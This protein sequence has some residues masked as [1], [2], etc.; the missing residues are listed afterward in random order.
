MGSLGAGACGFVVPDLAGT[1]TGGTLYN[2]QLIAA[3]ERAGVRC[4]HGSA[5]D[6]AF[7][8]GRGAT[9]YWVDSLYLPAWSRLRARLAPARVG[10]LVHYLPS[11]VAH[12]RELSAGELDH[13][14]RA[15]LTGADAAL[16]TSPFMQRQLDR[17][18]FV[19]MVICVAPGVTLPPE[20]VRRVSSYPRITM[21]CNLVP[22]KGVLPFLDALGPGIGQSDRFR[23]TIVGALDHDAA[24]AARCRARIEGDPALRERVQLAGPQPHAQALSVLADSDLFVSASRMESYG[25]ALAEA[26]AL[27]IPVLARAGGNAAAHIDRMAGGR[28]T[29]DDQQLADALLELVRD[30]AELASRGH[31]AHQAANARSWDRAAAEFIEALARISPPPV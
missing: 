7:L 29:D 22:G 4:I 28:L 26:R 21:L 19:G 27:G 20:R 11:L 13:S 5:D 12:G 23:V 9:R 25:M 24:Y 16:V 31:A 15:A 3:L 1:A 8:D 10:L 17:L 2:A 18:G 6:D 30:P 14:E